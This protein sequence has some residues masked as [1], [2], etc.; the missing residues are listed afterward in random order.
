MSQVYEATGKLLPRHRVGR[1]QQCCQTPY[2]AH[3]NVAPISNRTEAEGPLCAVSL[4][5][6]LMAVGAAGMM[7][8]MM[9]VPPVCVSHS[10]GPAKQLLQAVWPVGIL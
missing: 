5:Q 3:G 6:C 10:S 4:L 7:V 9:V 2:K 8:F 1:N